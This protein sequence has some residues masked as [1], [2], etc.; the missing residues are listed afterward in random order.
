M[1][2]S[3]I[4]HLVIIKDSLLIKKADNNKTLDALR[5]K[6]HLFQNDI[7]SFNKQQENIN[8]LLNAIEAEL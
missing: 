1:Q 2:T 7:K 3:K 5:K 4:E 8:E 6:K